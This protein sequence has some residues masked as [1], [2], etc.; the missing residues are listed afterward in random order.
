MQITIELIVIFVP[1][2]ASDFLIYQRLIY[3]SFISK[4]ENSK[5]RAHINGYTKAYW[6]FSY[7]EKKSLLNQLNWS[8]TGCHSHMLSIKHNT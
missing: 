1:V 3:W 5:G 7:T 8:V 6:D 2:C 4:N